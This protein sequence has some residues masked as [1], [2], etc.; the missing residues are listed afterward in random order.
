MLDCSIKILGRKSFVA[1]SGYD[2]WKGRV[3]H[4]GFH[5]ARL[6]ETDSLTLCDH[7]QILVYS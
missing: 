5:A 7:L 3:S 1:E 2:K 4:L 6:M